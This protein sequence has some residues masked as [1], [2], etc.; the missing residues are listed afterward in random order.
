MARMVETTA[1]ATDV[2]FPFAWL[3]RGGG[4]VGESVGDADVGKAV[5]GSDGESV[6]E[7]VGDADVGK[8]V[9][10]SDGEVGGEVG[11]EVG[12]GVGD[13]DIGLHK[14]PKT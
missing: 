5:G 2:W 11:D 7:S 8:A 13:G 14:V 9:G 1:T 12:D 3:S 10:G 6:G 4:V